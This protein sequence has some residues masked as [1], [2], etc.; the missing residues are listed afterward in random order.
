MRIPIYQV[1]AF[2]NQLFAGNPAAVCPFE[3]WLSGR[4]MQQIAAENN[5]SET[6]F[7]VP[8]GQGYDL[9]WFTP[10]TE[11]DLCGHATLATAHVLFQHEQVQED[12]LHFY[13][14]SGTLTVSRQGQQYMM[15]FPVDILEP[16]LA[17]R[18]LAEALQVEPKEVQLGREDYLV[19]VDTEAEVR[20]LQ[21]D[22]RK[23]KSVNSRGVIVS[24]PGEE[25]DFVSRCFFPNY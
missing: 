7:F 24:A 12:T 15:D 13:T 10:T 9:R 5:L 19:V 1:D 21:P 3:Q 20:A 17:P 22:F 6:A 14:R 18:V 2:T 8:K 16:A 4:Q 23:L 11:V 25:V